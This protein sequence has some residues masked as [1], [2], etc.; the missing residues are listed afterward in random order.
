MTFN[1]TIGASSEIRGFNFNPNGEG[2]SSDQERSLAL[3]SFYPAPQG[4]SSA[5][6]SQWARPRA[7]HTF[8]RDLEGFNSGSE[9]LELGEIDDGRSVGSG[10]DREGVMQSPKYFQGEGDEQDG[11]KSKQPAFDELMR[12]EWGGAVGE[13]V[14]DGSEIGRDYRELATSQRQEEE[15]NRFFDFKLTIGSI[16]EKVAA[17]SNLLSVI[18]DINKEEPFE[19]RKKN[20]TGSHK[21]QFT[22]AAT[23]QQV[24]RFERFSIL[25][26]SF[27]FSA[28][29]T[30]EVAKGTF[31]MDVAS[32]Y[33]P[34]DDEL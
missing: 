12:E 9:D 21:F 6:L 29:K 32:G 20:R 4:A 22:K 16:G 1:S 19:S 24:P 11:P 34:S 10:F 27:N 23:S 25:P 5:P 28:Q 30:M 15:M 26:G 3:G 8:D 2:Y 7:P 18:E 31:A 33:I 17:N 13:K 14:E